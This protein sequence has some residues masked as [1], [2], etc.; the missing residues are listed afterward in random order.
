VNH[1]AGVFNSLFNNRRQG[2]SSL[3]RIR[4]AIVDAL[5]VDALVRMPT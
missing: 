2:P 4:H 1:R 3:A 5:V